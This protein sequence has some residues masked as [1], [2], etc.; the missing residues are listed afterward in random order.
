MKAL[1]LIACA[2]AP[3]SARA[4][5]VTS[6]PWGVTKDGTAVQ[7]YT[8]SNNH[9]VTAKI[10]NYGAI[11]TS[12]SVPDKHGKIADVVLGYDKLDDYIKA[13]PYFGACRSF[14]FWLCACR[15][16]SRQPPPA[17][18]RGKCPGTA[19]GLTRIRDVW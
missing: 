16:T 5:S 13:T 8:L 12:L 7:L 18:V 17:P 9:G 6:V 19:W 11:V 14:K 3:L 15:R 4:G 2:L 1:L 10:T